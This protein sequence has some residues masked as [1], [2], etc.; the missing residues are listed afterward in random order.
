MARSPPAADAPNP[1]PVN[2]GFF[3]VKN[4]PIIFKK[5]ASRS[6]HDRAETMSI[7]SLQEANH[8]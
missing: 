2:H 5:I 7:R 3:F 1:K 4:R 8:D 6:P